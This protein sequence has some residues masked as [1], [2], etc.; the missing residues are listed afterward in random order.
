MKFISKY[1]KKISLIGFILLYI[2][3]LNIDSSYELDLTPL[4]ELSLKDLNKNVR[5]VGYAVDQQNIKGHLFFKIKD[6]ETTVNAA[7]FFYN[8][9]L[10]K[11]IKYVYEGKLSLNKKEIQ[12]IISEIKY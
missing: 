2:L 5:I 1:S 6:N 10:D 9:T 11:S 8:D 4:D 3:I 12:I 7:A